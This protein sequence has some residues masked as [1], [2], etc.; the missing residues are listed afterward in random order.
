LRPW[1]PSGCPTP[2]I[3]EPDQTDL[4]HERRLLRA[5]ARRYAGRTPLQDPDLSPLNASLEGLPPVHLSVGLRDLFLS[6][7]RVAKLQLEENGAE[8]HH[9]E[10]NGRL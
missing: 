1:P 2:A 7:V 3:T 8:V 6:E 10:I 9:R 4:V 5:A